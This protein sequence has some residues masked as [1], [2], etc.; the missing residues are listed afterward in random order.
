MV[1]GNTATGD[2][3][4]IDVRDADRNAALNDSIVAGNTDTGTPSDVTG[5]GFSIMTS[6][7]GVNTGSNIAAVPGKVGAAGTPVDAQLGPLAENGGF[8]PTHVIGATSP[9]LDYHAAGPAAPPRSTPISVWWRARRARATAAPSSAPPTRRR[10][11]RRSHRH[12]R[13]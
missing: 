13:S 11:R 4:G 2:G 3:G 12:P 1:T 7:V 6:I 10:R 5:P 8:T 9:A